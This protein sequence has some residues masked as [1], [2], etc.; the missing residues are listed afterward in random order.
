M[1]RPSLLFRLWILLLCG[2]IIGT[3]ILGVVSYSNYVRGV[4]TNQER[5]WSLYGLRFAQE[6]V[7]KSLVRAENGSMRLQP[8]EELRTYMERAPR[9]RYGAFDL[10]SG[11]AL[12]GSSPELASSLR[13]QRWHISHPFGF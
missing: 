9:F 13:I 2:Q 5:S 11:E 12:P 6:L 1:A 3:L 7:V 4:L 8:T 10:N